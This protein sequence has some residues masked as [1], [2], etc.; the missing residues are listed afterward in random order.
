MNLIEQIKALE[1]SHLSSEVRRSKE[2]LDKLLADD[3][4]EFGSSGRIWNKSEIIEMLVSSRDEPGLQRNISDYVVK[5]LSENVVLATYL[6]TC[7]L[8]DGNIK[9]CSLRSTIW[10]RNES[11][12]WQMMFHHGTKTE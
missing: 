8:A 10:I 12:D 3:F 7:Y 5:I 4:R 6:C 9:S 2:K 11:S 1:E